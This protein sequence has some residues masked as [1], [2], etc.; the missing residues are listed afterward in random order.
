MRKRLIATMG[1]VVVA[2]MLMAADCGDSAN[3]RD[4]KTVEEQ[5]L[6]YT[7]RQPVPRFDFSQD[8][9]TMIQI[10]RLRNEVRPTFTVVRAAGTGTIEFECPSR[11][12][13]IPA[14]TQLTNPLGPQYNNSSIVVEQPEP[15]GLYSSKNTDGTWVL[16]VRDDGSVNPVYT[17]SKVTTFPFRV[18]H[19]DGSPYVIDAK[20]VSSTTVTLRNAQG[21][22]PG[23]A[24][25]DLAAPEASPS[26]GPR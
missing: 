19:D 3:R 24:P 2:L 4:N 5:Q 15:N 9:D 6:V 25:S 26:P 14:D 20:Q 13:A 1:L 11:G 22:T 23:N 12:Y 18:T 8:R 17:E 7:S 16:C 10:Y 21:T